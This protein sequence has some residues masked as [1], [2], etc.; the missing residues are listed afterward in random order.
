MVQLRANVLE[1]NI[2]FP[3]SGV[4]I[5]VPNTRIFIADQEYGTGTLCVAERLL[6]EKGAYLLN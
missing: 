2:V 1:K 4:K 5:E 3:T 6:I